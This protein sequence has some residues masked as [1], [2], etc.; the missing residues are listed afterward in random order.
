VTPEELQE[1][2]E[3]EEMERLEAELGVDASPYPYKPG[4]LMTKGGPV[5]T[6]GP[7]GLQAMDA[8]PDPTKQAQA[9]KGINPDFQMPTRESFVQSLV[10]NPE[11]KDAFVN[12]YIKAAFPNSPTRKNDQGEWEFIDPHTKRWTV[13]YPSAAAT[14]GEIPEAVFSTLGTAGL[15]A[16]GAPGGP[17]GVAAGG[18]AGAGLGQLAGDLVRQKMGQAFG[19]NQTQT[20]GSM[21]DAAL[22]E[23][24]MTAAIDLGVSGIYGAGRGI[25]TWLFGR[26]V[27]KPHEAAA[28]LNS[29]A[30]AD[31]LVSEVN[32]KVGGIFQPTTAQRAVQAHPGQD[33]AEKMLTAQSQA[34]TDPYV[35]NEI[36]GLQQKNERALDQYFDAMTLEQ[37]MGG[38]QMTPGQGGEPL[39]TALDA[40]KKQAMDA[41]KDALS[42]LPTS[43]D[44]AEAGRKIRESLS[45]KYN[46][47]KAKTDAAYGDYKT[48][49]NEGS[50]SPST[51]AVPWSNEVKGLQK[52]IQDAIER[53][54]RTRSKTSREGLVLKTDKEIN[55]TDLDDLLKDLRYDIRQGTKGK[56]DVP[57]NLRDAKRLE[58]SLTKMRN[59]YLEQNEPKAYE[60]LLTAE[61]AQTDEANT[62]RYGLTRN[63]LTEES[64]G[65]FKISDAAVIG[66]ILKNQ[67]AAAAKEI[68]DIIRSNPDAMLQ[69]QQ[70]LFAA[71][72]RAVDPK[73]GLVPDVNGHRRFMEKYG[74]VVR[75]FFTPEQAAKLDQLGGFADVIA[76]NTAVVKALNNAWAKDFSGRLKSFSAEDLTEAV[77][78]KFDVDEVRKLKVLADAY[79]PGVSNAW[80]QGVAEDLRQRLFKG[81]SIDPARLQALVSDGDRMRKLSIVFGP[82]YISDLNTLNDAMKMITRMAR[83]IDRFPK[84]TLF[85]DIARASYA[86]PLSQGGRVVT[87]GQNNRARSYMNGVWRALSDP[88]ELSSLATRTAR[89]M[90]TMM[91]V[92]VASTAVQKLE[93]LQHDE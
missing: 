92:N 23:A 85:T 89:T 3:L 59:D 12:S 22:P 52:E 15:A 50:N 61:K 39:R 35:G 72:R 66:K 62:F 37:R 49:I 81:E 63:L 74:P 30:Q 42:T 38:P 13:A 21:T 34:R 46:A 56:L 5:A 78:G 76:G 45:A 70:F 90:R 17:V 80:R 48:I 68:A 60:A 88:E 77:N 18:A 27:L 29:Q 7:Q 31:A 79:G 84:N 14:L 55:L 26:Q 20:L 91:G 93:D 75:E 54:P 19:V 9:A 73:R 8:P 32:Q 51:I 57:L 10:T 2:Q 64:K 87:L 44:R 86:S 47:A 71:Y 67:D 58:K 6:Q 36:A 69:T 82:K 43:A 25:K 33:T 65:K 41:G 83:D 1:L 11:E 4:K 40:E 53:S 28:L 16:A 24:G